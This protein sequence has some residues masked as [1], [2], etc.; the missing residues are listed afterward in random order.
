MGAAFFLD[1]RRGL[2]P[3]AEDECAAVDA[4]GLCAWA[5]AAAALG[6]RRPGRLALEGI[7]TRTR[8]WTS[9]GDE[10]LRTMGGNLGASSDWRAIAAWLGNGRT[11]GGVEARWRELD[12]WRRPRRVG[13]PTRTSTPTPLSGA[14]VGSHQRGPHR[15]TRLLSSSRSDTQRPR[16]AIK[17]RE[18][19]QKRG[20]QDNP[21]QKAHVA[22]GVCPT[23]TP[24]TPRIA[25][26][27]GPNARAR[28]PT[29]R[30]GRGRDTAAP[31]VARRGDTPARGRRGRTKG[32]RGRGT[33]SW[34][35][36]SR[37]CCSRDES[38]GRRRVGNTGAR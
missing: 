27:G 13:R 16:A 30:S 4:A 36:G 1:A 25:M 6:T 22:R 15:P 12:Q 5:R 11:A 33:E 2:A 7:P 19:S 14:R 18:K 9:N 24:R 38:D 17:K 34:R 31:L 37:R 35:L 21:K 23:V 29:G 3:G 32:D 20:L 8:P 26:T 10:R 28:R